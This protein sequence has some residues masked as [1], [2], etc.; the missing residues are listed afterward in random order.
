[1]ACEEE[2]TW[3]VYIQGQ[4]GLSIDKWMVIMSAEQP[5]NIPAQFHAFEKEL[6]DCVYDNGI[7]RAKR[8]CKLEYNDCSEYFH[9]QKMMEYLGKIMKQ[10]EKLMKEGKVT[11]PDHQYSDKEEARL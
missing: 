1:M 2:R 11:H 5:Y 3:M 6:G 4:L 7:V 9:R 10:K 8:K